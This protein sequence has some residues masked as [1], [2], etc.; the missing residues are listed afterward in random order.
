MRRA[1]VAFPFVT[2]QGFAGGTFMSMVRDVSSGYFNECEIRCYA[3][4][5][6][7]MARNLACRDA[8][9]LGVDEVLWLDSDMDWPPNVLRILREAD[10]DIACIDM[11]TRAAPSRRT[12]LK[13]DRERQAFVSW[14]GRPDGVVEVDACGMACTLVRVPLIVSMMAQAR[15]V[16]MPEDQWFFQADAG[17]D[18]L[19]C[20]RAARMGASI[21]CDFRHAA[22]HWGSY[23]FAGQPLAEDEAGSL[24]VW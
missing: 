20:E 22:G 9:K 5:T 2:K 7:T 11:W 16:G 10:A 1:L 14:P 12:V 21:R 17:E 13:L 3:D 23:R 19:F 6:T 15:D 24:N 4:Q 8:I 18:V